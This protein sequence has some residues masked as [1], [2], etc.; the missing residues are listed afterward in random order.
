MSMHNDYSKFCLSG[1]WC[2]QYHTGGH[3]G[4]Y[5]RPCGFDV[6]SMKELSDSNT[7]LENPMIEA[8]PWGAQAEP[9]S[10]VQSPK[11]PVAIFFIA[12]VAATVFF[13]KKITFPG[14]KNDAHGTALL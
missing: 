3:C 10:L 11:Y 7:T 5:A 1:S 9:V 14:T 8:V 6:A 4:C 13:F 12:M 2:Y